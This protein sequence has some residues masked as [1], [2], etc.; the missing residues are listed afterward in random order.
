MLDRKLRPSPL[1]F[2]QM[3]LLLS[4]ILG[5][6]VLHPTAAAAATKRAEACQEA[7]SAFQAGSFAAAVAI[8]QDLAEQRRAAAQNNLARTNLKG[9]GTAQDEAEAYLW[10]L[11]AAEQGQANA[12]KN[13]LLPANRTVT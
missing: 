11:A 5:F 4:C 9:W 6:A 13:E 7:L 1:P 3:A 8:W 12:G 10:F 2:L